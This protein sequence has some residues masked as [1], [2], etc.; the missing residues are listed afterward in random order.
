MA[1]ELILFFCM[2][3]VGE[4]MKGRLTATKTTGLLSKMV[5]GGR[6]KAMHTATESV[7]LA[8]GGGR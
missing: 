5:V 3:V 8:L 6:S 1:L 2:V 7:V 4:G